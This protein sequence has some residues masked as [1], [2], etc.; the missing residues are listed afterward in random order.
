M[1]RDLALLADG[2]RGAVIGPQGDIVWLCVPRWNDEPVFA[3][4][5]GGAGEF[6]VTPTDP[7]HVW[8]GSY[9]PASLV[10]RSRW[11]GHDGMIDCDEALNYPAD[12]S[13]AVLLRRVRGVTG[14]AKVQVVLEPV[15]GFNGTPVKN[16]TLE[17]DVWTGTAGDLHVRVSGL[18]AATIERPGRLAAELDIPAGS[19][20]D[21]VVELT[22]DELSD[23][24]PEADE[25]WT[26]T[27]SAW[28]RAV[29]QLE[30]V[31]SRQ[32]VRQSYAVL[33][34]LTSVD[35]GM[36]AAATLSLPER[37]R[38]GRNY[39]YRY[40]WIRDQCY[41]GQAIAALGPYS[42]LDS[43]LAFVTDR[44]LEH[45]ADLRPAYTVSGESV[46]DEHHAGLP[47]YPGGG[48]VV[49]NWVNDQFQLDT[50]GEALS[51]Y[52][53]AAPHGLLQPRHWEAV[54]TCVEVIEQKWGEPDAGIWELDNDLY[55]Q[56][57]L[58]CVAGLRA[59]SRHVDA[60]EAA[61]WL[62]LADRILAKTSD[63]SLHPTGRW[64]QSPTQERVD[65]SLL[66]PTVRGGIAPDDPRSVATRS[67][68]MRELTRD[69][70][71]YR[72]RHD[73]RPL[74]EAEGSFT[75]CGLILALAQAQVGDQTKAIHYFERAR[76]SCTNSG[77]YTEEYD[78][79]E[80]QLRGNLPQAFVHA[81]FI[82]AAARLSTHFDTGPDFHNPQERR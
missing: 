28:D 31:H 63:T 79:R 34:G 6:T 62:A 70:H 53:A 23:D 50:L 57:R 45:G 43:A 21:I 7:W 58:A 12:L 17:N 71:V 69:G 1:L 19:H 9:E 24:P 47:G 72:F 66:L 64:Q 14:P 46:P 35:H 81:F 52:A 60:A 20:H 74:E 27:R 10:W 13:T 77:L 30:T 78:V 16:F 49:G 51:M 56:S 82:E 67:A 40:A 4:L 3:S 22:R 44:L 2:E 80:H 68:V 41:A 25:L 55:T 37:A 38:E 39:D 61:P 5:L 32:N 76:A 73:Q 42:L 54:D 18:A 65:A 29:P 15:G 8:G 75:L 33:A 11:V 26:A 36:V 59:I 48:D